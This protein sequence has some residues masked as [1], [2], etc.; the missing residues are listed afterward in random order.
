M[1]ELILKPLGEINS[2]YLMDAPNY[3][4]TIDRANVEAAK[5]QIGWTVLQGM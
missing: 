5:R 2:S 3:I 4:A 1:D